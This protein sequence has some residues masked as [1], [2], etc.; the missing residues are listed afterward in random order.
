V[1]LAGAG[2]LRRARRWQP[3]QRAAERADG[4]P[5]NRVFFYVQHLLGIGHVRR[6]AT[7]ARAL[8][9]G[10]FDVLLVSGGAPTPLELGKARL[11][12]LPPVRARDP[13]LRELSRLDGT[14]LDDAFRAA[15]R[16]ELLALLGAEAPQV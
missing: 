8:A 10:G 7:L 1:A 2:F 14:P 16:A 12:Q 6:A 9:T 4:R 3:R 5:M 15:R 13:G 11:H